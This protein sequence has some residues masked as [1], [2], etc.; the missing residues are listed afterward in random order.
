MGALGKQGLSKSVIWG[1]YIKTNNLDHRELIYNPQKTVIKFVDCNKP[2]LQAPVP[3][4]PWLGI[5]DARNFGHKC[6]V[7]DDLLKMSENVTKTVDL[8]D[9]L[10]LEIYTP[11]VRFQ[12]WNFSSFLNICVVF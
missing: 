1:C 11:K 6:P 5:R 3:V 10:S 8:E 2:I 12:A 4:K 9:C 7:L